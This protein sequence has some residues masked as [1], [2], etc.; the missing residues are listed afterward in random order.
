MEEGR[1][2]LVGSRC[3]AFMHVEASGTS[4]GRNNPCPTR[5]LAPPEAGSMSNMELNQPVRPD[6][7]TTTL[8]KH[9]ASVYQSRVC[10]LDCF[11]SPDPLLLVDFT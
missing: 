11:V 5:N 9:S 7:E 10:Y 6:D 4:L 2:A 3:Q 1:G 8:M